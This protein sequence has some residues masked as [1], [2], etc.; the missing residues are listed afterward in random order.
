[1]ARSLTAPVPLDTLE[2]AFD[3]LQ[4][5]TAA[6]WFRYLIGVAPLIFTLLFVWND[7]SSAGGTRDNAVFAAL[8]L[9]VVLIW[10]YRCRQI[11]SGRL[12]RIVGSANGVSGD[13]V[14]PGWSTACFEGVKVLVMPVAFVS[15]LPLS[16]ATAFFRSLTLFAGEGLN[17]RDAAAKASKTCTV[18]QRE[19]W[20]TLAILTLLVL[21]VFINVALTVILAPLLV[22]IFTG[23]ESVST[24]R[25]TAAF[26][27]Q[28]PIILA[29]TWL[30]LDP[31][32]QAVYVVRA[33]KWEGQ[34]TGE[35]LLVRLQRL[36]P[37]LV[38]AACAAGF[39]LTAAPPPPTLTRNT[40]NQSIDQTLQSS[41]YDW[42]NPPPD[43]GPEK[44]DWFI[45]TVDNIVTFIR[46]GWNIVSKAWSD[47]VR[48]IE[49]A[50]RPILPAM[51][52]TQTGKPS[53]VRPVFYGI[54]I[55][56][57]AI[58]IILLWKF[59]PRRKPLQT[60]PIPVAKSVD[61][62]NEGLLA[63]D[64]PEDE[65]LQMAD[66]YLTSGDLRLALRAL[67][68]GTL[69]LL[70]HRGFLTIHACK[71]NRDYE[72]ELRRRS[73]D[74]GL[75]GIFGHNVRSFEQSW[76]GFH[77]VTGEQLQDF[78]DNLGRMRAHAS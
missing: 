74:A 37:L 53:G 35:D 58:A 72:R 17:A 34:S 41:Q 64:L 44:K 54:G 9:V 38:F 77:P 73:R 1:M 25:G 30:C 4:R 50:L 20:F 49:A 18:W 43:Q 61:L 69:A 8:L 71:S 47:L 57:L 63:S 67:Y 19:N 66:R 31:L 78:R 59:G 3:L 26:S 11:F 23:Y 5:A 36:A 68:L 62:N 75:S 10:F 45:D 7:F 6:V 13:I 2:E 12:R 56:I 40:L 14:R 24:E 32:L 76:Y 55:A 27:I 65:W 46:K 52:R 51:D 22:K 42:R 28:F 48:W 70:S 15:L 29:L 39:S 21:A 16:Y 60:L 33:F